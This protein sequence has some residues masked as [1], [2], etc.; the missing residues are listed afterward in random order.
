MEI[1]ENLPTDQV[2]FCSSN[3]AIFEEEFE[4]KLVLPL[5][6]SCFT[7]LIEISLSSL[8]KSCSASILSA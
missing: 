3:I 2:K 5:F 6:D 8:S 7:V 1:D 4:W